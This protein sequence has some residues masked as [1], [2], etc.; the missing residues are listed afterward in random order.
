MITGIDKRH[1]SQMEAG[2][3]LPN[4]FHLAR[5]SRVLDE[6]GLRAVQRHNEVRPDYQVSYKGR[7]PEGYTLL[8]YIP[9]SELQSGDLIAY[10]P[11]YLHK[12]APWILVL[13]VDHQDTIAVVETQESFR[14]TLPSNRPVR[15]ARV[16]E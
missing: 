2:E 6:E 10:R 4:E 16:K 1:L 3:M 13:S 12:G 8:K 15:V 7:P 14:I 9:V 11:P 5:L